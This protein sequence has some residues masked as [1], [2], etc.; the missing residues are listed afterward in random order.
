MILQIYLPCKYGSEVTTN[1]EN[2]TNSLYNSNWYDVSLS[3]KK[4]IFIYM[5]YLKHSTIVKAGNFFIISLGVFTQ[6][7]FIIVD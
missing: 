4:D 5:E 7:S 3:I 6:V 1:A 2:L